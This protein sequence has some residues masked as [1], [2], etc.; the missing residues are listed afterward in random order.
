M[1]SEQKAPSESRPGRF[2]VLLVLVLAFGGLA[3]GL[4]ST[5][6]R[7]PGHEFEKV[8]GISDQQRIFGGVRQLDDRLGDENAPV[9]V[10]IFTDVQCVEC[11]D[12]FLETIPPLVSNEVREGDVQLLFRNRSLTRNATELGFYGVEAAGEQGY[13]WQFAYL[14][15]RNQ[16]EARVVRL[17]QEF[18]TKIA[19]SITHLDILEWTKAYT[20]GLKP[21]SEMNQVLQDQDT[22]A[23]DLK[24]RAEPAAVVSGPGGTEI[25]QDSPDLEE[26]QQ[27]IDSVR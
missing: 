25:V 8:L 13:A 6:T 4:I 9:Q 7:K 18:L 22:L 23:F 1:D 21:G 2:W 3:I 11:K 14:L 26:I 10:Q 5:A 20:D 12:Q 15:F 24:I 27:A 19:E 17:D 16:E